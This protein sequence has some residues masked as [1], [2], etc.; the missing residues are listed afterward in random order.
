M[1]HFSLIACGL[2]NK[3]LNAI[4]KLEDSNQEDIKPWG[5]NIEDHFT[6][7]STRETA[8][9]QRKCPKQTSYSRQH[10]WRLCDCKIGKEICPLQDWA[11]KQNYVLIGTCWR[12]RHLII[13]QK[14]ESQLAVIGS[15]G[16][17]AYWTSIPDFRQVTVLPVLKPRLQLVS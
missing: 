6:L 1:L 13:G 12:E 16:E 11:R 17:V 4:Y 10:G 7:L 2:S 8:L 5:E 9:A 14:K 15:T 3:N